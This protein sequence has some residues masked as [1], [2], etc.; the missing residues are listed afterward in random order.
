MPRSLVQIHIHVSFSI[1]ILMSLMVDVEFD[2]E[3]HNYPLRFCRKS[4]IYSTSKNM[5]KSQKLIILE[6]SLEGPV[7]EHPNSSFLPP[8]L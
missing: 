1:R 4:L 7:N 8:L 3:M 6:V 2:K 5:Q